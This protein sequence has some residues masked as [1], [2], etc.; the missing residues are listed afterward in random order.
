MQGTVYCLKNSNVS[1]VPVYNLTL[2]Y[3]K[4]CSNIIYLGHYVSTQML[5]VS[6]LD[7]VKVLKFGIGMT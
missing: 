6:C 5:H 1:Y 7:P 4:P 3:D 2:C